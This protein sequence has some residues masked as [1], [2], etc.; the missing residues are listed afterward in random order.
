MVQNE[1]PEYVINDKYDT[2]N[3]GD[4]AKFFLRRGQVKPLPEIL[5]PNV[6]NALMAGD[7]REPTKREMEDY[8]FEQDLEL[9]VREGLVKAGNTYDQ[10]V[11]NYYEYLAMEAKAKAKV[12]EKSKPE[13]KEA[14]PE[15]PKEVTTPKVVTED[16]TPKDDKPSEPEKPQ[17]RVLTPSNTP[18]LSPQQQKPSVTSKF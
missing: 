10:T 2:W 13:V 7:L 12:E 18:N 1:Y 3:S 14:K 17:P 6:I 4:E 9:K 15:K 8:E 16:K 5:T 11:Q